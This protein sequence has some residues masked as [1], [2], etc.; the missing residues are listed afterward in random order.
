MSFYCEHCHEKNTEVQ[1]AGEIKQLGMRVSLRLDDMPDLSRQ[2]VKSDTAIFRIE[3]LDFEIPTGR[4]R[5]TNIEGFLS[6]ALKDLELD[7]AQRKQETPEIYEKI[8]VVVQKL[9]KMLNGGAFPFTVTISDTAGNSWI[10]PSPEDVKDKNKYVSLDFRRTPEENAS[11]GLVSDL[12]EDAN[13]PDTANVPSEN[14]EATNE[15]F[16]ILEGKKYTM[17]T[18]CPGCS[19][20]AAMNMQMV[21]IPYFKQVII[22]AVV[23]LHC[24]YR[25]S[26]VKTGGEVPAQ[27]RRI[28]LD[29]ERTEDLKRD[30]LK[31]ETCRL[32]VPKCGLDVQPG[33]MG[34]RFTTL[35]GL[36]TQ[37]RD[38]L[39]ASIFDTDDVGAGDSMQS[40]TKTA[41][42]T[43]FTTLDK[44]I[45][46]E[47]PFTVLMEDALAGSY[48]QSFTAPEPDPQIRVEDYDRT[49]E[50]EDDLG[51]SDMKTH[52][53]AEGEYVKEEIRADIPV[54]DKEQTDAKDGLLTSTT[55]H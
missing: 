45:N 12:P 32:I 37:I 25:T 52:L 42:Q 18:D 27:G 55:H 50:E 36:L 16:D 23:C 26:D 47:M 8:E 31:S 6:D 2:V 19:K 46:A 17:P 9:I 39:R 44:A 30:I 51:L 20:S 11:L 48:V 21:N 54:G 33:S 5:L 41:W 4:G 22:T 28:W 3:E 13:V 35:E 38:D 34:G 24:G 10:E 29:V 43:F 49:E 53:N 14:N 15:E 7:Q 40:E 1:F